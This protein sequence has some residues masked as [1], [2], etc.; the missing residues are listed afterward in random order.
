MPNAITNLK[1]T[2]N[3]LGIR[4]GKKYLWKL[5]LERG[6]KSGIFFQG[7]YNLRKFIKNAPKN[8]EKEYSF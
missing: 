2:G 3:I 5:K 8:F 4:G 6:K 1:Q 7:S